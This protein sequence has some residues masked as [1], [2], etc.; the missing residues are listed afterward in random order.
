[1]KITKLVSVET[2]VD[3]HVILEDVVAC[4]GEDTDSKHTI[5]TGLNKVAVFLRAI[6]A[7]KIAELHP[8]VCRLMYSFLHEQA[9]R[10]ERVND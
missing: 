8:T 4:I 7:D 2:E 1:M 5:S 6:P 10:Y 3:A 9:K